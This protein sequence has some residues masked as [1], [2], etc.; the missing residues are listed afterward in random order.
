MEVGKQGGLLDLVVD[1]EEVAVGQWLK[2][3]SREEELDLGRSTNA[4]QA[5][6]P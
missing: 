3:G 2:D 6:S 1:G 4:H 5:L